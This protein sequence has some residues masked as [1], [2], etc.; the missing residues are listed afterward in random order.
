MTQ[1]D[2]A[3]TA[4]RGSRKIS[5]DQAAR[6]MIQEIERGRDVIPV[7]LVRPLLAINRIAP[8]LAARLLRDA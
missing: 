7:G 3:M 2:T 4:G 6:T 8:S 5:P 1:V